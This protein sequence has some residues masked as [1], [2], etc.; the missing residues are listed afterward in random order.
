MQSTRDI[1][2][3]QASADAPRFE[4][5]RAELLLVV[6][7]F[8]TILVADRLVM[9]LPERH[10]V[11]PQVFANQLQ[12][13]AHELREEPVDVLVVGS[14]RVQAGVDPNLI[15]EVLALDPK[16]DLECARV[17]VQGMRAWTLWKLVD[18]LL[19]RKPPTDL[20]VIGIEARYF[21]ELPFEAAEPMGFR[22]M[23]DSGDLFDTDL[24]E[25]EP[26]HIAQLALRAFRGVQTP[27]NAPLL[28]AGDL[29]DYVDHLHESRGLPEYDFR[30]LSRR[31]FLFA[32]DLAQKI[33]AREEQPLPDALRDFELTAFRR[34]LERLGDFDCRVAFVRM[35][36]ESDFDTDQA[37]PLA[38]YERDVVAPILAAGH[39]YLDLNDFPHL[40]RPD[41]FKNPTHVNRA[42]RVQASRVL[43]WE[44]IAPV[45]LGPPP[46]GFDP[47]TEYAQ[48]AAQPLWFDRSVDPPIPAELAESVEELQAERADP[49]TSEERRAAIELELFELREKTVERLREEWRARTTE[50]RED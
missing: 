10:L 26:D 21:Y 17:V 25:L 39:E 13:Y 5:G 44:M 4:L 12:I 36:V 2:H 47:A 1:P 42:G 48:V 43:A 14:S 29:S 37:A 3:S 18:D 41:F 11:P 24:E 32:L 28:L 45:L 49:D 23:A 40:Q 46:E 27:W 19:A 22:L 20:L 9:R 8:A 31:E 35:P 33:D 34:A 50:S 16:R 38:A 6:A 7:F 30:E 15:T